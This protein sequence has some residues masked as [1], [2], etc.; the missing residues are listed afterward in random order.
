MAS[1]FK[2]SNGTRIGTVHSVIEGNKLVKN[3]CRQSYVLTGEE[4]KALADAI[5][6]LGQILIDGDDDA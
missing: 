3:N 1:I 6:A 5:L 2:D 4:E